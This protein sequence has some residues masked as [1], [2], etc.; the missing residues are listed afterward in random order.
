MKIAELMEGKK[1][2]KVNVRVPAYLREK[3]GAKQEGIVR[4]IV[5]MASVMKVEVSVNRRL[6]LFHIRRTSPA[7]RSSQ[8]I[9]MIGIFC[10]MRVSGNPDMKI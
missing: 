4:R 5:P 10:S 3:L 7:S 6:Y 9:G 2:K 1:G 8:R